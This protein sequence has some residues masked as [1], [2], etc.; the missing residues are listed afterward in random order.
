MWYLSDPDWPGPN[1]T[2][3]RNA[4]QQT[5]WDGP[6]PDEEN[7]RMI[8]C[9]RLGKIVWKNA[10][11]DVKPF[12]ERIGDVELLTPENFGKLLNCSLG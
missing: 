9:Q 6:F 8:L 1:L 2:L 5:S 12:L 11:A 7:W 4:L 10:V 3:L